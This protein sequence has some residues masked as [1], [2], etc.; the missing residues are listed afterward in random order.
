M[1]DCE[2]RVH[3]ERNKAGSGHQCQ[4]DQGLKTEHNPNAKMMATEFNVEENAQ[5]LDGFTKCE[6]GH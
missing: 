1:Q 3:M 4:C 2:F 5:F 6:D